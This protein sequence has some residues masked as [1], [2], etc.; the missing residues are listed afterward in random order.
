[1]IHKRSKWKGPIIKKKIIEKIKK[2]SNRIFIIFSRNSIITPLCL[3]LKFQITTGKIFNMVTITENMI[4]H[5]FG[6]F[7]ATR[8]NF[9]FKKT[10]K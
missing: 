5:K 4:G 6:E 9:F 1:M 2:N 7:A 3:G 10:K 8:K